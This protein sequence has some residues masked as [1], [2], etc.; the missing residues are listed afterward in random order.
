M[1]DKVL[2]NQYKTEEKIT[3]VLKQVQNNVFENVNT[4]LEKFM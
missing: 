4:V 3:E 2:G 1:G